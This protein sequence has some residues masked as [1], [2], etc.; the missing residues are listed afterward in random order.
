MPR[1][2]LTGIVSTGLIGCI[3]S[4]EPAEPGLP[5]GSAPASPDTGVARLTRTEYKN[6]LRDLLGDRSQATSF[7]HPHQTYVRGVFDN[8]AEILGSGLPSADKYELV[9]D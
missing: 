6:S 4:V 8:N 5:S 7:L 1:L 3:G 2:L 9:A